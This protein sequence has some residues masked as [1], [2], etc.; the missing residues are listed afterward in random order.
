MNRWSVVQ[1]AVQ[2]AVADSAPCRPPIAMVAI[3]TIISRPK[4]SASA[5]KI[6][7]ASAEP[8]PA[9]REAPII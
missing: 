5:P 9:A 2:G 4:P 1:L 3:G 6:I 7:N 8:Q